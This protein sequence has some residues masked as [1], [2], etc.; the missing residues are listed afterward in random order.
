LKIPPILF[1]G[2][3]PAEPTLTGAG[4]K[5]AVGPAEARGQEKAGSSFRSGTAESAQVAHKGELPEAYGTGKVLLLAREPHWLYAHWDLTREQQRRYNARSI[6]HHLV[7]RVHAE[8]DI[9]RPD[10]EQHLH[11]DSRCWFVHVNEAATKYVAELGYYRAENK[12]VSI[13]SSAAVATPP[14]AVSL[15]R[16]AQ[17]ASVP[18]LTLGRTAARGR[19]VERRMLVQGELFQQG[20]E[21]VQIAGELGGGAQGTALPAAPEWALTR[22]QLIA[23]ESGLYESGREQAGSIEVEEL[24][25]G[26]F[27]ELASISSPWGGEQARPKEFLLNVNTDLIIHGG[28]EPTATLTI[29]GQP[30]AL[31]PD[32]TFSCRVALPDGEYEAVIEAVSIQGESRSVRLKVVRC[33]QAR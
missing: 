27:A 15:D 21:V 11:T 25:R 7:L 24:V 6:Y 9:G 19:V 3:Q 29:N 5:F 13:G 10:V 33:T 18:G 14:D 26:Q 16:S 30:L 31:R 20:A 4:K 32:G 28:T 22:E 1:E 23:E 2:D 8:G 17:F 12:W